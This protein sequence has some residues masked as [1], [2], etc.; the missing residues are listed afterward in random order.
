MKIVTLCMIAFLSL[1]GVAVGSDGPGQ[2]GNGSAKDRTS[3]IFD[4]LPEAKG[5][6]GGGGDI[7]RIGGAVGN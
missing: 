3:T 6:A 4:E 5:S 2:D 7:N 1:G